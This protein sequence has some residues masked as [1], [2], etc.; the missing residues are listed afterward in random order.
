MCLV[1]FHFTSIQESTETFT[2]Y[3]NNAYNMLLRCSADDRLGI[4][5]RLS[6]T[7]FVISRNK[8][9]KKIILCAGHSGTTSWRNARSHEVADMLIALRTSR[10]ARTCNRLLLLRNC[11]ARTRNPA[12]LS[13]VCR[14]SHVYIRCLGC[15][16]YAREYYIRLA[17]RAR[18]S[19]INTMSWLQVPWSN[20]TDHCRSKRREIIER[21][22]PE[23]HLRELE[24]LGDSRRNFLDL[25]RAKHS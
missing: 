20:H 23:T 9:R 17:G 25:I 4:N 11:I 14:N 7:S 24:T 13:R 2:D 15:S 8:G 5:D 22:N 19:D 12:C 3:L 1:I 18:R 6:I 21:I 16:V 10:E